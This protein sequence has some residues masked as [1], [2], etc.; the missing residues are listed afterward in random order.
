MMDKSMTKKLKARWT[1]GNTSS[2]VW[3]LLYARTHLYP[4]GNEMCPPF[5][6]KVGHPHNQR[7]LKAKL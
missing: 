4:R 7:D 5:Y 1:D 3:L 6:N 2:V